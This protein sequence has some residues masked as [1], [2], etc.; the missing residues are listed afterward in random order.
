MT[1]R[2]IMVAAPRSGGGKT[3]LT[4]A[5]LAA[6]GRRGLRVGAVKTGP[7]YIDPAFHA[8]ITGRPGLN[9]DSWCMPDALL[10]RVMQ[11]ACQDVDILVVE[12]AMGLFDGLSLP[13]GQRGAPSDIAAHF[14]I[15]VLLVLDMSGQGQSVGPIAR[16][17]AQ[18]SPHV[19][20]SGVVLNR[21]ASPRHERLGREAVQAAQ[22]PV[23]GALM[24]QMGQTLP[25]RHL[26]LV[27]AREHGNLAGWL[28]DLADK[29]E[30]ELDLDGIL[31]AARP[32]QGGVG[33]ELPQT[34]VL[35]PPGQRIAVADDAAFSFLYGHLALF[36]RQAGAEL[37][38]FSPLADE[39][40]DP[41]CTACWLPGGYPELHAGVLAG[42]AIFRTGLADF[43]R[44]RPVHGECGGFMVLG[45]GLEDAQGVRHGMA[46]LLGH[47][48][49]FARRKLNLGYRE[50][51][52]VADGV[53]GARGARLRGH[54][55]HY[56]TVLEGG[57]DAPLASLR[58]GIGEELGVC[59]GQRGFVS[60]SF[61]HVLA[62]VPEPITMSC[63]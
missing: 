44:T 58:S 50:A 52:L 47:S 60:G 45:Q 63:A 8:A 23:Y 31:A 17:F 54:E 15:P 19:Q 43:A 38:P 41:S 30:R 28:A 35:P 9:L 32:L 62:S 36:W 53:L 40:P 51:T 37:V 27:Q 57:Q 10:G 33:E 7:D 61:F 5:L 24:R 18:W 6:F 34:G 3:T 48:T 14:G 21:V 2:A 11:A 25:E 1:T 26:G 12:S 42:A 22:L 4:L 29:A 46:G 16:G 55:F 39:A 56:A 13:D 59:G 49:S 20:V